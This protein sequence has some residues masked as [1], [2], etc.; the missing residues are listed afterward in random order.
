[1]ETKQVKGLFTVGD[2]AGVSGGIV[3]AAVTGLIAAEEILRREKK[4]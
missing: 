3:P 4:K 2:G 1:M